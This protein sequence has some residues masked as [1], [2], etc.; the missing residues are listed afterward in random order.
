M[1]NLSLASEPVSPIQIG[2]LADA[3]RKAEGNPNYGILK[4]IKGKNYR[5][6]CIQTINHALKDFKLTAE[7]SKPTFNTAKFL[8]FLGN[9]YCPTSGASL[10]PAEKRLNGNWIK[11][12]SHFYALGVKKISPKYKVHIVKA[13][14]KTVLNV[15]GNPTN[16]GGM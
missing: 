12:V 1:E 8:S 6:A 2:A 15:M 3:I 11:S 5:K 4:K 9:R 13:S 7:G 14:Y 10:R 16:K